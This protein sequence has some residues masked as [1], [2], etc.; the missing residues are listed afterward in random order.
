MPR[1]SCAP[2]ADRPISQRA[3]PP[4]L[5]R[6]RDAWVGPPPRG[7]SCRL[8]LSPRP[9]ANPFELLPYLLLSYR[10]FVWIRLEGQQAIYF[11]ELALAHRLRDLD[12]AVEFLDLELVSGAQAHAVAD[13]LRDDE[14]AGLVDG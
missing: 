5:V 10:R 13:L 2:P 12:L 3:E 11:H 7:P 4:G 6:G 8:F 1:P 9:L 14:T